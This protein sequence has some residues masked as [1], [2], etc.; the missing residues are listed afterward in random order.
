MFG[1][2]LRRKL[3]ERLHELINDS[4]ALKE[5]L[6]LQIDSLSKNLST[7]VFHFAKELASATPGITHKPG[8]LWWGAVGETITQLAQE[9]G[10]LLPTILEAE[11]VVKNML[12]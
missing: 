5:N 1:S 6:L 10:K 7:L 8:A 9:G 2:L 3:V 4:S 12:I 11:N